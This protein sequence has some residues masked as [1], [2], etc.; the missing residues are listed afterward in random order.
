MPNKLIGLR[1]SQKIIKKLE[2]IAHHNNQSVNAVAKN[3]I[4]EWLD[5]FSRTRQQGMI[6]LGKTLLTN[7]LDLVSINQL[8]EF[9]EIT[10]SRK[11]DLFQFIIG[12]DLNKETLDKF[13]KH[14]PKILGSRGLMWFDHIEV[15]R[16]DK[17]VHFRGVHSLGEKWP[18]FLIYFFNHIMEESFSMK[19]NEESLRHS[20]NSLFLEYS[21]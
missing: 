15:T 18:Q 16:K 1:L 17:I 19:L 5:I 3:A 12:K 21:L 11:V 9:A 2:V 4:I 8:K 6:I 7:L 20:E 13:V 10:A 14:A